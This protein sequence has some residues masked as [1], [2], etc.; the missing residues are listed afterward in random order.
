MRLVEREADFRQ[1]QR[2]SED[3][4]AALPRRMEL[5]FELEKRL[6]LTEIAEAVRQEIDDGTERRLIVGV[7]VAHWSKAETDY[8]GSQ[9]FQVIDGAGE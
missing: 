8:F 2:I 4:I 5:L 1:L 7:D 9:T 3:E 6:A